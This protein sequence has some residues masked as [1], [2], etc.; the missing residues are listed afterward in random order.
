MDAYLGYNM[1]PMHPTDKKK[2]RRSWKIQ[3]NT[4]KMCQL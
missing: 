2:R 4:T 1:I 3:K